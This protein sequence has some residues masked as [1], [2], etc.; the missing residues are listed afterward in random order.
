LTK[1]YLYGRMMGLVTAA[2]NSVDDWIRQMDPTMSLIL[3][4][5]GYPIHRHESIE[6]SRPVYEV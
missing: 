3:S 1:K 4:T 6:M 5:M 2:M